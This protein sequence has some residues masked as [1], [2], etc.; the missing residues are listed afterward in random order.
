MRSLSG[1]FH[2]AP[3]AEDPTFDPIQS[4]EP[5]DM[6]LSGVRTP[7]GKNWNPGL[8]INEP[9]LPKPSDPSS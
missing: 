4:R 3:Y 7:Y 9:G 2:P 8:P 5:V 6:M 1:S